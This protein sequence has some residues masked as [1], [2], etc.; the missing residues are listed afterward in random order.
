[1]GYVNEIISMWI[2]KERNNKEEMDLNMRRFRNRKSRRGRYN[3]SNRR[4]R[5]DRKN[6]VRMDL[7]KFRKKMDNVMVI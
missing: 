3:R 6:N 7:R 1:M 2:L 4:I 5:N